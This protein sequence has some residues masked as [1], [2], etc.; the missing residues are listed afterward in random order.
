VHKADELRTEA[1]KYF[2][3]VGRISEYREVQIDL[4]E[5]LTFFKDKSKRESAYLQEANKEIVA[6]TSKVTKLEFDIDTVRNL[7]QEVKIR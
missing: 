3:V 7:Y 1:E 2:A 5:Q 4:R 6:L